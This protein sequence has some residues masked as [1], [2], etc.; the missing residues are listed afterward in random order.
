MIICTFIAIIA[1]PVVVVD[2]ATITIVIAVYVA[3]VQFVQKV[4]KFI[5]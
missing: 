1:A 2:A 5:P 4:Y 3:P